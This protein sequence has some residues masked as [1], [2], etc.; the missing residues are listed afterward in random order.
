MDKFLARE[1]TP[2]QLKAIGERLK[3]ARK[4][5]GISQKQICDILGV[6]TATWNHWETGR[7][8]P[9]PMIITDMA[10]IYRVSLDWIY[11][12]KSSGELFSDE[13]KKAIGNRLRI[14][15]ETLEL[16]IEEIAEALSIPVDR[17]KSWEDGSEVP[18]LEVMTRFASRFA[19]SMDW[20]FLDDPSN[21]P[22]RLAKKMLKNAS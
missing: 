19:V 2:E 15:R 8:L 12:G 4:A 5:I 14:T 3:V 21:M 7:R 18:C 20:I 17:L 16:P 1:R 22:H 13:Q 10:N 9:D 6:R 11:N